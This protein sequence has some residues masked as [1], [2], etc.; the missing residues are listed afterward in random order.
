MGQN[1][2]REP[3]GSMTRSHSCAIG[4]AGTQRVARQ[5]LG[6]LVQEQR[7]SANCIEEAVDCAH[8][9]GP[10]H[11]TLW[12]SWERRG[13]ERP[14]RV[15]RRIEWVSYQIRIWSGG[16]DGE[17]EADGYVFLTLL[18]AEG[19]LEDRDDRAHASPDEQEGGEWQ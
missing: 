16:P 15:W 7:P 17:R 18:A 4:T 1:E 5:S 6:S 13:E 3:R 10:R 9:G 2:T 11:L 12:H 8:A 14:H 19:A